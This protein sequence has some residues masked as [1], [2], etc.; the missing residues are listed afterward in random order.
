MYFGCW[1]KSCLKSLKGKVIKSFVK[2][3]EWILLKSFGMNV[4]LV[5]E[6]DELVFNE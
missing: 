6:K 4:G 3:C 1:Y 2:E 5:L